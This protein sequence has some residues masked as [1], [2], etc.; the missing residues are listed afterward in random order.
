[1]NVTKTD[2]E[3]I[4]YAAAHGVPVV[5]SAADEESE[6]HNLPAV[7]ENTIVVN[8]VTH[9][10][11]YSPAELP[12][13]ST[14]APTY[15]ANISVSVESNSCSSE[16]TGKTGGIVGLAESAAAVAMA[17]HVIAPYPGL[18][19]A[20]GA[21][22]PLS[23]NEIT[24]LVTMSADDIDFAT[25]APPNGPAEQHDGR[26]AACPWSPRQRDPTG[27]GFDAT[28]GYGRIDADRLVQWIASGTHPAP[29][30][31][32]R[33][34]LVPGA[35]HPS[36]TVTVSGVMGTTRSPSWRYEVQVAPGEV[37]SSSAW[38]VVSSG[39][40]TGVRTGR[41]GPHPAVQGGRPV[42]QVDQAGRLTGRRQRPAPSRQVHVHRPGGRPGRGRHGGHGPA[43]RVP[44]RGPEP[45]RR[46]TDPSSRVRSPRHRC[47]PPSAPAGP[48]RSWWPR[49]TAP[50][51]PT[52]PMG[53]T[54]PG[55][56]CA[57]HRTPAT[58]PVRRPTRQERCRPFPAVRSSAASPSA[59][60]PTHRGT[61][62]TWWPPTSPDGCGRGTPRA[63]SCRAGRC[64]PMPP[65][66]G[67]GW[68]TPTT[69]CS[70]ASSRAPVLGDLQ[71]NGTLDVVAASM[72]RHVYAWQPGGQPAPGWPVEV[73]DPNEVQSVDPS[74]GQVTFL[75]TA[76]GDTGTKL[77][78]TPAIAQLVPGRAAPGDRHLERAVLRSPQ[79]L[80]RDHRDALLAP[81]AALRGGQQPCLRHLARRGAPPGHGRSARPTGLSQPRRLPPRVAG[82]NRRPRPQPAPRHR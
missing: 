20:S 68:P 40:G 31:D 5:A 34:A 46:G 51:T 9:D 26:T 67:P 35:C 3:A 65:S 72:D 59:T 25:A 39:T 27:P 12:L 16:A 7:L 53:P 15:G 66:P 23:V 4:T 6:H 29:G 33:A 1:M 32:R 60:W 24:Q 38:R 58:T 13:S 37:P 8:S 80:A 73:V 43:D 57:R 49:P 45:G 78:D 22:V 18:H 28:S 82:G 44:P 10:S 21:P 14:A 52:A 50:S 75:P 62:S 41:D 48:M 30:R 61:I 11:S 69:R 71:G 36:Q 79:R 64:E 19:T 55:G 63:S 56:R 17:D 70:A 77:V 2:T 74:N 81:R 47:S 54:S 76:G 42:P